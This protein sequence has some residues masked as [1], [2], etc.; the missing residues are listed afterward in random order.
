MAK[1]LSKEI[2]ELQG[3]VSMSYRWLPSCSQLAEDCIGLHALQKYFHVNVLKAMAGPSSWATV[4][5]YSAWATVPGL[6]CLGYSAWATV[7]G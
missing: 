6:Q 7:P 5:G 4:P 2:A 1:G 3:P